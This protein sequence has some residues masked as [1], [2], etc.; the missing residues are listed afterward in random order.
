[1]FDAVSRLGL[2]VDGAWGT[3]LLTLHLGSAALEEDTHKQ[4]VPR[5]TAICLP[6]YQ[7]LTKDDAPIDPS[8]SLSK[9]LQS[10]GRDSTA[11]NSIGLRAIGLD[12]ET[13]VGINLLIPDNACVPAFAAWENSLTEKEDKVAL[14]RTGEI[15]P[16]RRFY[17]ERKLELLHSNRDAFR[18]VRRQSPLK[19]HSPARLGNSYE[20]FRRLEAFTSYWEDPTNPEPAPDLRSD[21]G[22]A[23]SSAMT[24]EAAAEP[25][26]DVGI[27]IGSGESMPTDF[28]HSLITAFIK[29]VAYDFS[30]N[31]VRSSTEPRLQLSSP[32]NC[33]AR[34]KSYIPSHCQ[35]VFQGPLTKTAAR[36]G[37][38]SGPVAAVSVRATTNFSVPDI[39]TAQARDLAQEVLAALLTAQHRSRQDK[40]EQ[41]FG[42]G[43]WWATRPRWG[44]GAGGPI[45]KEANRDSLSPEDTASVIGDNPENLH[46]PT[47][48]RKNL[49]VYDRYRMVRPS[50]HNW[51]RRATYE[52][53][54]KQYGTNYDDV[55]VVSSLYHHVSFLRVRVPVRLL[56]VLN[57]SPEPDASWRSWGKLPAWRTKWFDLFEGEQRVQAMQNMLAIMAYQMREDTGYGALTRDQPSIL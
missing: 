48:P 41:K 14:L 34:R 50:S 49:A 10:T 32:S 54:G 11:L 17:L 23:S 51:D 36:L 8:L 40:S 3:H 44:G 15:S 22:L 26:D 20:F 9:L 18:T 57:G 37:L 53:I 45:G 42:E 39:E 38:V 16:G 21:E 30:C 6:H 55:F 56:E 52:L 19:G 2:F 43:E 4:D 29:L 47:K 1:M 28:R 46:L 13:D 12:L 5:P 7:A 35:F 33:T 24:T 27:R 25:E 31:V